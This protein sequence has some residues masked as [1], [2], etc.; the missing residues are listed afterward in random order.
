MDF[1]NYL[2]ATAQEIDKRLVAF[3]EQQIEESFKVS[4]RLKPLVTTFSAQSE[5]GKRLRGCLVRLGY[6]L[7][8]SFNPEIY[9]A[10]LAYEIVQTSLLS[11]DDIIDKSSIRRGK[12][13]MYQ[14]LGGDHYGTS[15]TIILGDIGFFLSFQLITN[16]DFPVKRK[17]KALETFND[18]LLKTAAG[19]MLD[20]EISLK[21]KED[22]SKEDSLKISHLKTAHYTIIGPLQ[23]GA[24][25][26]GGKDRFLEVL[27]EFGKNLGIAFQ[28]QDDILGIFGDEKTL[29]KST[30]SDISEGKPT[31]LY[32]EALKRANQAQKEVLKDLYG[33]AD[34][35]DR[36][37]EK[38]RELFKDLGALDFANKKALEYVSK[39]KLVIPKISKDQKKQRLLEELADFLVK[40]DK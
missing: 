22:F 32:L 38:I 12:K 3:L 2:T 29:G 8:E 4:P 19:E 23:L 26:A 17:L 16:A 25:L 6:E 21:G 1:K 39:A 40:R 15:Q 31:L 35:T 36:A 5:G 14:S 33:K 7:I 34:I 24:S 37:A 20:I 13:T 9:Q 18:S 30:L 28:I 27:E 11:H 10:S